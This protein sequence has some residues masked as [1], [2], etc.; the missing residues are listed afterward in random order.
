MDETLITTAQTLIDAKEYPPTHSYDA[1]TLMPRYPLDQ[2]W[3]LLRTHCKDMFVAYRFLD[4]GCSK[5]FFSLMAAGR[6]ARVV[7]IDP[8]QEA[9]DCW[10]GICPPN[11]AQH[12]IGFKDFHA[13]TRFDSIWIGNGHHYLYRED[14]DY[15]EHLAE[16][17][18]MS[19]VIEGPTGPECREMKT[20]GAYQHEK[21]FLEAMAPHFELINRIPSPSYT[22][23]RAV[24][25]FYKTN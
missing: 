6:S 22:P 13:H 24:W 16:L 14:P 10:A 23:G 1:K 8:D 3:S 18:S 11:V 20:F 12:C 21:D 25:Q 15:I 9:L 2:R 19:V 17:S 7:S 4:V 5:G